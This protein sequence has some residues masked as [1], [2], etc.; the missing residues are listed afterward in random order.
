MASEALL[1]IST[2]ANRTGQYNIS[3]FQSDGVTPQDLTGAV[4]HFYAGAIHKYSPASGITITS[5]PNGTAQLQLDPAD[6]VALSA[7]N[8]YSELTMALSGNVY[9]L[10]L[11]SLSVIVGAY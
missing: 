3:V 1:N 9:S 10:S 4:L 8:I 11:G 7:G 6:T 5:V 2:V